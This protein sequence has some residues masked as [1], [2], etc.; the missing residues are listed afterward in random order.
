MEKIKK[1]KFLNSYEFNNE[2][3]DFSD[4]KSEDKVKNTNIANCAEI[5][6]VKLPVKISE[7]KKQ[8]KKNGEKF[9]S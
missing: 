7:L 4:P 8:Y 6:E 9:S 1:Y 2:N 3:L 5:L